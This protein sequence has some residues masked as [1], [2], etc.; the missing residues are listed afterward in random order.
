M[1]YGCQIDTNSKVFKD[2]FT[3]C[4]RGRPIMKIIPPQ[5]EV[6]RVLQF[7]KRSAILKIF[8]LTLAVLFLKSLSRRIPIF[9][10][11]FFPK[12]HLT[13]QSYQG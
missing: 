6:E 13:L 2:F 1:Y 11:N 12:G 7:L 4:R 9:E 10:D 8:N 5:W 3:A